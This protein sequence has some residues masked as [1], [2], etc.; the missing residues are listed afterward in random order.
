MAVHVAQAVVELDI[1][2][3]RAGEVGSHDP[4]V[5][6]ARFLAEGLEALA[7]EAFELAGVVCGDVAREELEPA[8]PV[9]F[10]KSLPEATHGLGGHERQVEGLS[11]GRGETLEAAAVAELVRRLHDLQQRGVKPLDG[12][13]SEGRI[14]LRIDV[15]VRCLG[16]RRGGGGPARPVGS[17]VLGERA[18]RQEDRE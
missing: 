5:A 15:L 2:L 11:D 9:R 7:R 1:L 16:S 17:A 13:G 4:G 10:R 14:G 12:G 3:V 8:L 6:K 18:E